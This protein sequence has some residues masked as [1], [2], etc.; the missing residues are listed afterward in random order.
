MNPNICCVIYYSNLAESCQELKE[1]MMAAKALALWFYVCYNGI[2]YFLRKITLDMDRTV[3]CCPFVEK[4]GVSHRCSKPDPSQPGSPAITPF[5]EVI[6][7]PL[8]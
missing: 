6:I 4:R 3:R 8:R 1:A 2:V 7:L 5:T